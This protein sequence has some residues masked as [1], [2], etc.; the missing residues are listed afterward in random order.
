[1]QLSPRNERIEQKC[2]ALIIDIYEK[3]TMAVETLEETEPIAICSLS[4]R[5]N[6]AQTVHNDTWRY[7]QRSKLGRK[8]NLQYA[9]DVIQFATGQEQLQTM[10]PK[11]SEQSNKVG[12]KINK[13]ET[14]KNNKKYLKSK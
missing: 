9:G 5:P 8:G 13:I 6:I 1:M 3:T 14:V 7:I 4:G 12:L 11:L 10:I 2:I